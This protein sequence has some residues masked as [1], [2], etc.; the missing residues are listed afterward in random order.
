MHIEKNLNKSQKYEQPKDDKKTNFEAKKPK[1]QIDDRIA[2]LEQIL[3]LNNINV[4]Y[5]T[6][7]KP[8]KS[9]HIQWNSMIAFVIVVVVVV[10]FIPLLLL[11]HLTFNAVRFTSLWSCWNRVF[12]IIII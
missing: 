7:M 9:F 8:Q 6:F 1:Y 12:S 10:L 3:M 2:K 5:V 11:V 4:K